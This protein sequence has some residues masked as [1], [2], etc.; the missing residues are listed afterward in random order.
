MG[1][2]HR[3]YKLQKKEISIQRIIEMMKRLDEK[4]CVGNKKIFH[5]EFN[6]ETPEKLSKIAG[7]FKILNN[8]LLLQF[9]IVDSN[10]L[11]KFFEKTNLYEKAYF[12]KT[13]NKSSEQ[14]YLGYWI[15]ID[16]TLGTFHIN[17]NLPYQLGV[18]KSKLEFCK[19]LKYLVK[20]RLLFMGDK[21][22][23]YLSEK[24]IDLNTDNSS[25]QWAYKRGNIEFLSAGGATLKGSKKL[26][27]TTVRLNF[28][29]QSHSQNENHIK[30]A[31]EFH[32]SLNKYFVS[33]DYLVRGTIIIKPESELLT[34]L[35]SINFLEFKIPISVDVNSKTDFSFSDLDLSKNEENNLTIEN[36]DWLD[37]NPNHGDN[38]L[39]LWLKSN[40]EYDFEIEVSKQIEE[41]YYKKIEDVL[42]EK[43]FYAAIE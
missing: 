9:K 5:Y 2:T 40:N 24:V 39:N 11:N 4:L 38:R 30:R 10:Q 13:Q 27:P 6:V 21:E 31:I 7:D 37:S 35:S 25:G 18:E 32:K 19:V 26:V 43:L 3:I 41:E 29:K 1:T 22:V 14:K 20:E 23:E 8:N 36:F 16:N 34:Q 42:E 33:S 15:N 17:L 12:Y 28:K